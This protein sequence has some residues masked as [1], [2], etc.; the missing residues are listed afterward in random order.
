VEADLRAAGLALER[1]YTDPDD[2]FALSLATPAAS[3]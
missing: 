2:M 1:W 3:D